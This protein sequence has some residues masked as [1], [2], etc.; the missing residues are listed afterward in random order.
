MN[1]LSRE[2]F[3]AACGALKITRGNSLRAEGPLQS[4]SNLFFEDV[5]ALKR[6]LGV[7]GMSRSF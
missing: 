2:R 3:G 4:W 1:P 6:G 7:K 5:E